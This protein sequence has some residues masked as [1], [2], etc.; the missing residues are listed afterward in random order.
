M[1]VHFVDAAPECPLI[2]PPW[3]FLRDPL[4]LDG[5]KMFCRSCFHSK[6]RCVWNVEWS[7]RE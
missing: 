7:D 5:L 1:N 2:P 3:S 6:Y 4:E